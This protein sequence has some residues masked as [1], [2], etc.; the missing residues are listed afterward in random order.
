MKTLLFLS[1]R[2][3]NFA[4]QHTDGRRFDV[5]NAPITLAYAAIRELVARVFGGEP[6]EYTIHCDAGRMDPFTADS[7]LPRPSTLYVGDRMVIVSAGHAL[8]ARLAAH[9]SAR[10]EGDVILV[11]QHAVR[12][13]LDRTLTAAGVRRATKEFIK[14]SEG[15]EFRDLTLA[16]LHERSPRVALPSMFIDGAQHVVTFFSAPKPKMAV[17][18]GAGGGTNSFAAAGDDDD[19]YSALKSAMAV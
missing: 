8:A 1:A 17:M 15:A 18:V 9:P 3:M 4:L 10:R 13:A 16:A 2:A 6:E 19:D 14:T 5:R 7:P 12:D 11:P